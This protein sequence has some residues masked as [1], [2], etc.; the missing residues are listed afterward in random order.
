MAAFYDYYYWLGNRGKC[1]NLLGSGKLS[2]NC[3]SILA[4]NINV[5]EAVAK[6]VYHWALKSY[7]EKQVPFISWYQMIHA[8]LARGIKLGGYKNYFLPVDATNIAEFDLQLVY[9]HKVC[10]SS[11]LAVFGLSRDFW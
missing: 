10:T 1:K 2:C 5:T 9:N 11:L 8:M 7:T 3:L 6:Y 4:T